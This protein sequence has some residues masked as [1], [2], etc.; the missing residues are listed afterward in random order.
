MKLKNVLVCAAGAALLTFVPGRAQAIVIDNEVVTVLNAQLII[1]WT[2]SDG[3]IKK[4]RI[5]SKEMVNAISEDFDENFSGDQIVNVAGNDVMCSTVADVTEA[6]DVA[7]E[8]GDYWLMDKH[9]NLVE[10]LTEDEVIVANY[11]DLSDSDNEGNNGKFKYV[12]TGVFDFE[13]YSDGDFID[14]G[15]GTSNSADSTL[16]FVDDS[17]PY[18][19][20]EI[21]SGI[22]NNGRQKLT[23]TE[24]DAIGAVGHDFDVVDLDDQI[25]FGMMTQNG[26]G[27]V[28]DGQ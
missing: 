18:T 20:I 23:I 28:V 27:T 3:K 16:T 12:E 9:G 15:P 2:D 10:N 13:F 7:A 24:K 19:F 17:A 5:T 11:D 22:K 6:A 1:K 25:I 14:V 21:G 8:K 26:S 4:A